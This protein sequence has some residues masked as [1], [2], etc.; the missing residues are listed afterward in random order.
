MTRWI[1]TFL[2]FLLTLLSSYLA[3]ESF[4]ESKIKEK[5]DAK[6]STLPIKVSYSDLNYYLLSNEIVIKNLKTSEF[7]ID[8]FV[9]RITIDLPLFARKKELPESLKVNVEG[10]IIP[11]GFPVVSG[12]LKTL[13]LSENLLEVDFQAGYLFEDDI[14]FSYLTTHLENLANFQL[15][16]SLKNLTRERL[17]KFL[18]GKT[19]NRY[20]I[21][22]IELAYLSL[23]YKDLGLLRTFLEYEAR[24]EGKTPEELKERFITAIEKNAENNPVFRERIA[25]PLISFIKNPKCLEIMVKPKK[26]LSLKSLKRFL[27]DHPDIIKII[28]VTALRFNICS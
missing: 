15:S 26:P 9:R 27:Q 23:K 5:L 1:F 18:K 4:V 14:F 17:E 28:E 13:G 7:G 20:L 21:G 10:L 12:L 22:K 16:V 2:F 25:Y 19:L 3:L 11:P 6:I 8:L 24:Q